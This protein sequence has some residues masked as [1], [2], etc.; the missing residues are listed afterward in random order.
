MYFYNE[1]IDEQKISE[2]RRNITHCNN[3]YNEFRPPL[4][5][6]CALLLPS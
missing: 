3:S 6:I 2:V 1:R 5:F 4:H